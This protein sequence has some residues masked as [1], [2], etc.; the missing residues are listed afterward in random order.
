MKSEDTVHEL[1]TC[2]PEKR[3]IKCVPTSLLFLP[4][5]S[6]APSQSPALLELVSFIYK[7]IS[8][9]WRQELPS[10]RDTTSSRDRKRKAVH[11]TGKTGRRCQ[12]VKDRSTNSNQCSITWH[13]YTGLFNPLAP[14]ATSSAVQMCIEIGTWQGRGGLNLISQEQR[15]LNVCWADGGVSGRGRS[16]APMGTGACPR[17]QGRATGD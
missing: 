15:P 11:T 2:P 8:A 10:V 16:P 9:D 5:H 13:D 6:H 14:P 17:L 4:L 1:L 7:D 3:K 12:G